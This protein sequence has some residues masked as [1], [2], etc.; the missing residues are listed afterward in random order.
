LS[1]G[2]LK[3]PVGQ[4][5]GPFRSGYGWHLVRVTQHDADRILSFAEARDRVELDFIQA[6]RDSR[7]NASFAKLA[8]KYSVVRT[9]S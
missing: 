1:N 7:N 8:K 9:P 2:V 4:W 3:A 6:A 5:S